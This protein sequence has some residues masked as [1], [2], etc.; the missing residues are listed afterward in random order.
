MASAAIRVLFCT[1]EE[2]SSV[3]QP[4]RS[5]VNVGSGAE[6]SIAD[7]AKLVADVVGYTGE[8]AFD[9]S[10]PDGTPR[11]LL[12]TTRIKKLGWSPSVEL[13][14]GLCETYKWFLQYEKNK[15]EK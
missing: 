14:S 5:H 15:G 1:K 7:L 4:M 12:E 9:R 13:E 10:K 6:I 2:M 8:I 11:K 3:A